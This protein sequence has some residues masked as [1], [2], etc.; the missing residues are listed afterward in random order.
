M[1]DTTHADL[2]QQ[3]PLSSLELRFLPLDFVM[4]WDRCGLAADYFAAHMAH[5]FG[6]RDAVR[7][8]LSTV[9]NELI[10][11]AVKF[12]SDKSHAAS[13]SMNNFGELIAFE[14]RNRT[15]ARRADALQVL[16]RALEA[17]S[18]EELFL[19]RIARPAE[20]AGSP[21]GLGL[22]VL[23]KDYGVRLAIKIEPVA[24][25]G[26]DVFVQAVMRSDDLEVR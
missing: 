23:E 26:F 24:D 2:S 25:G 11:N 21:S 19:A 4:E 17:Q 9:L 1:S 20:S 6:G 8:L 14:T 15:D 12:S 13:V 3:K 7:A 16:V 10:E 18:A 22:L 5:T